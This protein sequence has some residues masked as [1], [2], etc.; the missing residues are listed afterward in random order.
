M[1]QGFADGIQSKLD[2]VGRKSSSLAD[3]S[4]SILARK[5]HEGSPSKVTREIGRYFTEGFALGIGDADRL[6]SQAATQLSGSAVDA[7]YQPTGWQARTVNA[8]ISVNVTVNGNVEDYGE[9]AD[10]IADRIN[11]QVLQKQGAF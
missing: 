4:A 7:M 10:V 11:T 2:E 1:G 8:P 6:A 3:H 5:L 9:L